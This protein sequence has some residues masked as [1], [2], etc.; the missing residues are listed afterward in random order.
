MIWAG[1]T[2]YWA[3]GKIATFHCSFLANLTLD[4]TVVGTNGTLHVN[5]LVIP[6]EEN[7]APFSVASRSGFAKLESGWDP[8]PSKHVVVTELPQEALMVQEFSRLVQNIRDAGGKPEGKWPVI[9]RKTQVVMD[10]V[11]TSIGNGFE[12]VDVAS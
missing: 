1:A 9:T 12:P 8:L 7:S 4:I 2:L 11:K 10:A 6:Y 5:D 3:D